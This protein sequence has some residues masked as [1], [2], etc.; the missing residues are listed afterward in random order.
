MRTWNIDVLSNGTWVVASN[1][2]IKVIEL[3][4]MLDLLS[5]CREVVINENRKR[6]ELGDINRLARELREVLSENGRL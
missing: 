5:E 4:P 1:G 3:E 6:L 2:S